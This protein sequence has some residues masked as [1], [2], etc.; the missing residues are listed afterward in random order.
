MNEETKGFL[1][2]LTRHLESTSETDRLLKIELEGILERATE[3]DPPGGGVAGKITDAQM[4][5]IRRAITNGVADAAKVEAFSAK[6]WGL[7]GPRQMSKEQGARLIHA[8]QSGHLEPDE[9]EPPVDPPIEPGTLAAIDREMATLGDRLATVYLKVWLDG[10]ELFELTELQAQSLLAD[11]KAGEFTKP[12]DNPDR[13]PPTDPPVD[14]DGNYVRL[15][16][17]PTGTEPF[18]I[19]FASPHAFSNL[20]C[21]PISWGPE[22]SPTAYLC[23]GM[24]H[25]VTVTDEGMVPV[26]SLA[27]QEGRHEYQT[28][29]LR[30]YDGTGDQQTLVPD[31]TPRDVFGVRISAFARPWRRGIDEVEVYFGAEDYDV[32]ISRVSV[33]G[34]TQEVYCPDAVGEGGILLWDSNKPFRWLKGQ[35]TV[36]RFL[37]GTGI[38]EQDRERFRRFEH[39]GTLVG[40]A[41]YQSGGF[42][43]TRAALPRLDEMSV[44]WDVALERHEDGHARADHYEGHVT[45]D[46]P[47]HVAHPEFKNPAGIGPWHP[48]GDK[49][50]GG[51]GGAEIHP[52]SSWT[53]TPGE[54][55]A[56]WWAMRTMME[57][58]V[59]HVE[60][61]ESGGMASYKMHDT[62]HAIR[63]M[64][65]PLACAWG[66]GSPAARHWL[67]RLPD[68]YG[69]MS[70]FPSEFR[71]AGH[72]WAHRSIG[73]HATVWATAFAVTEPGEQRGQ[74]RAVCENAAKAMLD[75]AM[76][77]G[78]THRAAS[79]TDGGAFTA[80]LN[81]DLHKI[82]KL[83]KGTTVA[84]TFMV[85]IVVHGAWAL[86]TAVFGDGRMRLL[87]VDAVD[88]SL[89][90]TVP[91]RAHVIVGGLKIDEVYDPTQYAETDDAHGMWEGQWALAAAYR[92]SG[93]VKYLEQAARIMGHDSLD[94]LAYKEFQR[95]GSNRAWWDR[96]VEVIAEVQKLGAGVTA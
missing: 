71:G 80:F 87:V 24:V 89:F 13:D 31:S 18:P 49:G 53:M 22:G 63:A 61:R 86:E 38:T 19:R 58:M 12:A 7:S 70:G 93:D 3:P 15:W 50:G 14:P 17:E 6:E 48:R 1:T 85:A 33:G 76:P 84:R 90:H 56:S 30:I 54:L 83:P 2:K 73:W 21:E 92:M 9:K 4:D 42:G 66:L 27:M 32:E 34:D 68:Y 40:P 57:R 47:L 29:P 41:S 96:E 60:G 25:P 81:P 35:A 67:Q 43:P 37:I 51:T 45:V 8:I 69:E 52:Y 16:T 82:G 77:T 91:P 94:D 46:G 95:Q 28:W 88:S 20:D 23:E 75:V 59:R 65:S 5:W 36:R 62:A 78:I 39:F 79:V 64:V 44:G 10:K 74:I 72:K 11:L 55:R 26:A